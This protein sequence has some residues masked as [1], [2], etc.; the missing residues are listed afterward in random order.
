MQPTIESPYAEKEQLTQLISL[1]G[2]QATRQI[3]SQHSST[4]SSLLLTVSIQFQNVQ[5][6][7]CGDI[8]VGWVELQGISLL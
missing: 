6:E 2:L 7:L 3:I 4:R 5:S 1:R 8:H